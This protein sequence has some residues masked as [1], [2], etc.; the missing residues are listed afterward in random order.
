[1]E[2]SNGVSQM[3][4]FAR[5]RGRIKRKKQ[6]S[7]YIL[8]YFQQLLYLIRNMTTFFHII[9]RTYGHSYYYSCNFLFFG[10]S[11]LFK[12]YLYLLIKLVSIRMPIKPSLKTGYVS[13]IVVFQ[14]GLNDKLIAIIGIFR[15]VE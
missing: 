4:F 10:L 3:V 6:Y 13:S 9:Y 1:M 15:E 12:I 7:V 5:A 2:S 11:I 14:S 8:T